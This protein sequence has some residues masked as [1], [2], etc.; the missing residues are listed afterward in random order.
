VT[1]LQMPQRCS[2]RADA[3]RAIRQNPVHQDGGTACGVP[4]Y[5]GWGFF[6]L[7]TAP[8]SCSGRSITIFLKEYQGVERL[9]VRERRHIAQNGQVT[10][11][12]T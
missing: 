3:R 4:P 6:A 12:S 5:A 11:K 7:T 8:I 1:A 10:E 9:I 2:R